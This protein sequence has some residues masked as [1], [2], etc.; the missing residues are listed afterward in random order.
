[1]KKI[2]LLLG[3]IAGLL[4]NGCNEDKKDSSVSSNSD[5]T[6]LSGLNAKNFQKE[7][8]GKKSD[9]FVIKNGT[10]VEICVTSYGARIVSWLAPDKNGKMED[11]VLGYES[12]QEYIDSKEPYFGAAIGRYGNR[13]KEGKF[14]LDGVNYQ[15]PTNNPPNALHGGTVG[16]QALV[17]DTTQVDNQTL[18]FHLV[19]KD[20]DQGFPGTL[21]VTM[22][23]HLT[24]DNELEINYVA[25]T[26]KAT[27]INLTHHSFFNLHGAG[28]GS[29][30]DHLMMIDADRYTP[31]TSNLIPTGDLP[32][33]QGTPMDFRK[34]TAIGAR[35]DENF[36]QLKN[37]KGYDHN[38]V[39]NKE[40]NDLSLAARVVEPKSGRVLEVLTT[41]PGIQFYGGNFLDNSFKGK[42]GKVYDFRTAFCLETQHFPDSP[43]QKSF[44]SVVLRSGETY[45]HTCVYKFYA[46]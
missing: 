16:F 18:S 2:L 28:N 13:I 22:T 42:G 32:S 29:V 17:W 40:N 35:V 6:T 25:T 4:L 27:V 24:D 41:E 9:L 15:I 11:I 1:M 7:I 34:P 20:G 38:W 14:T 12:V 36:E 3:I 30:N 46:E 10:G 45:R 26:D 5:G 8:N 44:P 33:V 19:S 39:L 43:N 21:D 23:Y 31:V 37:G